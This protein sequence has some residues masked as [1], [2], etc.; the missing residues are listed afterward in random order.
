MVGYILMHYRS[1]IL[2]GPFGRIIA[3]ALL[4]SA[5]SGRQF[6]APHHELVTIA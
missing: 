4:A 3:G 2:M 1:R 5:A 6:S